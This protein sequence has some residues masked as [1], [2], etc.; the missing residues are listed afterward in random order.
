MLCAGLQPHTDANLSAAGDYAEHLGMAFQI[1]DDLLDATSTTET[2]GK[3]VGSDQTNGK[4]TFVSL[5]GRE[6]SSALVLE[7]T[8]LAQEAL[9]RFQGNTAIFGTAG[10][11]VGWTRPLKS[12]DDDMVN[13]VLVLSACSWA[14]AQVLKFLLSAITNRKFELYYLLTGGGMPSSHS[15]FCLHLCYLYRYFDR[16]GLGDLCHQCCAG[17]GGDV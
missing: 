4:H 3:P 12:G 11:G 15:S 6:D 17:P 14:L 1:R 8:R 16:S 13:Q 10:G 2:L 5:L 7:H 9:K